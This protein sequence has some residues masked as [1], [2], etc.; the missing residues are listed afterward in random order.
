MNNNLT[1][2]LLV[3]HFNIYFKIKYLL[4]IL[5]KNRFIQSI[6][7]NSNWQMD[8]LHSKLIH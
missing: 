3:L 6:K 4:G 7:L 8:K 2:Y 5:G 1:M